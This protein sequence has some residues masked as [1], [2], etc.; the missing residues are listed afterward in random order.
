MTARLGESH[1]F[2]NLIDTNC[3]P[4]ALRCT[5]DFGDKVFQVLI[6]VTSVIFYLFFL[7]LVPN[8]NRINSK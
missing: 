6:V 1:I 4:R 3:I 7:S 8:D 2:M 5:A